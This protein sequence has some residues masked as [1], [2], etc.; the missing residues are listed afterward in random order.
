VNRIVDYWPSTCERC[1]TALPLAS[2]GDDPPPSWHQVAVVPP[3]PALITEHLGHGSHCPACGHG[4]RAEISAEI[5]AHAFGSNLAAM[6]VLMS[7]LCRGSKRI[8]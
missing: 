1:Q 2:Q 8:I 7:A 5:R 6:V 4:T 3:V